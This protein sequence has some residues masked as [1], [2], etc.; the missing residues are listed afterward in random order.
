MPSSPSPASA[1]PS[2]RACRAQANSAPLSDKTLYG[3]ANPAFTSSLTSTPGSPDTIL[4]ITVTAPSAGQAVISLNTQLWTDFP[5]SGATRLTNIVDVA[6]CGAPN[7][8]SPP[9]AARTSYWFHKEPNAGSDDSTF[10]FSLTS[11]L[12]FS[13]AG[14]RTLYINARSSTYNAGLWGA[15][16]AHVD[17]QFTP[18]NPISN[19]SQVTVSATT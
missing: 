5:S 6:R 8:I 18:K 16:N 7:T 10:P 13:G 17:V 3:K 12:N 2:A 4:A 9:C 15:T 11:Q 1:A 19:N 14:S